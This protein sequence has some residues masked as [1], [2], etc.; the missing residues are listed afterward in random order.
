MSPSPDDRK[1]LIAEKWWDQ[2][3][4]PIYSELER[5]PCSEEWFEVYRI[6]DPHSH[7]WLMSGLSQI[8]RQSLSY[9]L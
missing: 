8:G 2:Q 9:P 4:R 1:L 6:M 3:P 5:V 7:Q